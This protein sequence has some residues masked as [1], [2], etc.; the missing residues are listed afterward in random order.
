MKHKSLRTIALLLVLVLLS[1]A[2]HK[3]EPKPSPEADS[4]PEKRRFGVTFDSFVMERWLRDRDVLLAATE[5]LGVDL[6]VQNPNGDPQEQAKQIDYF[7]EIGCDAIF[8][9]PIDPTV[10]TASLRRAHEAGIKIIAYD[11]L[12]VDQPMDLYISFDNE[13]VG[14]LAGEAI[15]EAAPEGGTVAMIRGASTD[16]N[17]T[18][19]GRGIRN[20]LEAAENFDIIYDAN[21]EEWRGEESY[22]M[23]LEALELAE[24]QGKELDFIYCGNDALALEAI[25]ALATHRLTG[26]VLVTGQD[27]DLTACQQIVEGSQLMTVYKPIELLATTAAEAAYELVTTDELPENAVLLEDGE[28]EVPAILLEPIPV[29]RENIDEVIIDGGFHHRED[30]YRAH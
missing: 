23:T 26:T 13:A 4:T 10:L 14:R 18:Q 11:R 15:V 1:S 29:T 20:E 17:T 12:L 9:V 2:C 8:V 3:P 22:R 27:A 28:T 21:A 25:K 30:V 16:H 6:N 24:S 19:A 5:D 7:V